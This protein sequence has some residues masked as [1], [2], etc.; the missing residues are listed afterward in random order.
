LEREKEILR[1]KTVSIN[2]FLRLFLVERQ[3]GFSGESLVGRREADSR[4]PF[5]F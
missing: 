3:N 2:E 1:S 4:I 5:N